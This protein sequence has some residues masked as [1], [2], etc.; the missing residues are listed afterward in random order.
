MARKL[1]FID[2]IQLYFADDAHLK[3]FGSDNM[4][5]KDIGPLDQ[6][7]H[8]GPELSVFLGKKETRVQ[9]SAAGVLPE[10]PHR[11]SRQLGAAL[12]QIWEY[13]RPRSWW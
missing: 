6:Q 10:T 3:Q 8:N 12:N 7:Q 2:S 4:D 13:S 5:I 9:S 1:I 11:C